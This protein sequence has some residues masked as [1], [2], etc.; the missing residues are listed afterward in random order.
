MIEKGKLWRYLG[1]EDRSGCDLHSSKAKSAVPIMNDD[2][3][4]LLKKLTPPLVRLEPTVIDAT[5]QS[6]NSKM[7]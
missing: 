6:L 2:L 1:E 4:S 7:D 5:N 3:E